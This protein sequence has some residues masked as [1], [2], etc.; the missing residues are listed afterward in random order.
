MIDRLCH[1]L[2]LAQRSY[3]A[4]VSKFR[5]NEADGKDDYRM[6]HGI[7][8]I[9]VTKASRQFLISAENLPSYLKVGFSRLPQAYSLW[10]LGTALDHYIQAIDRDSA[11]AIGAGLVVA[12]E[13]L[14]SAYANGNTNREYHFGE[15]EEF[16]PVIP[17]MANQAVSQLEKHFPETT[18]R[19]K[20]DKDELSSWQSSFMNLNRRSFGRKIRS[21]L[22]ELGIEQPKS[23]VLHRYIDLR[24]DL[25]HNGYP[26]SSKDFS[27]DYRAIMQMADFLENIFLVILGYDGD[28][29][30]W[31]NYMHYL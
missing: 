2:S 29:V 19:L 10:N 11:W 15:M 6:L 25:V 22:D 4:K 31:D 5:F 20:S 7:R 13:C 26:V 30:G 12:L 23:D 1:L 21:M 17:D 27:G 8:G 9:Q 18:K 14:V 24:N 28:V 16:K 3:I